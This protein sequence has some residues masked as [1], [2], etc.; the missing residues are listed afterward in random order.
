MSVQVILAAVAQ[1]VVV[2]FLSN[3]NM[4]PAEI[5]TRLRAQFGDETVSRTRV[6]DELSHLKKAKQ[7]LETCKDYAFCEESYR[8]RFL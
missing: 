2:K 5:L 6:Y 3:E 7:R 4:K 1:R 8:Q